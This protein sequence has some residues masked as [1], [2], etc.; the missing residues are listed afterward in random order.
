MPDT[1]LIKQVQ[2]IIDNKSYTK[3]DTA[4]FR[5]FPNSA[6]PRDKAV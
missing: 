1:R 5:D 4:Y 6:L 3:F 2:K